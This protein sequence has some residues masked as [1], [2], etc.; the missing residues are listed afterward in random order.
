MRIHK[1]LI[2]YIKL[3]HTLY[4]IN[5][6]TKL[7]LTLGACVRVTVVVLCV[8]VCLSVC[9]HANCYIHIPCLRAQIAMLQ[10]SLWRP[11]VMICVDF[12]VC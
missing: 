10:G 8:C 7:S 3:D 11:K 2:F 12:T 4:S 5:Y 1:M 9:Y 6:G